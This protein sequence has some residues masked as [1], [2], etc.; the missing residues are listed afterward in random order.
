MCANTLVID[1]LKTNNSSTWHTTECITPFSLIYFCS[2]HVLL[3]S[4]F[5]HTNSNKSLQHL[6][7]AKEFPK[8]RF[9][10]HWSLK[11]LG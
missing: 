10:K 5:S 2:K 3:T 6:Y 4:I 11:T 1:I 7:F 8:I 9:F